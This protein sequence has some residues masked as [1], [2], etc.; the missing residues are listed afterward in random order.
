MVSWKCSFCEGSLPSNEQRKDHE[1]TCLKNPENRKM[2][3]SHFK[4]I[5]ELK[6]KRGNKI[7]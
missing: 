5:M 1:I 3:P 7:I 6:K 4:K 2:T